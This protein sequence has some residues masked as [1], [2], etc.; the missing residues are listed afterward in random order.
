M[1]NA[2][3]NQKLKDKIRDWLN[4]GDHRILIGNETAFINRACYELLRK[5]KREEK[6]Q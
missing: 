6:R 4:T 2:N 3:I 1:G 5:L